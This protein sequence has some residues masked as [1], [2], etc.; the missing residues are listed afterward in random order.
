MAYPDKLLADDEEIVEH[1]HPHWITLVPAVASFIVICAA[2][3]VGLAFLPDANAH[4]GAHKA[5]LIAVLVLAL[6]LLVWLVLIPVVRW[7]STH[8][9]IT[10]HRVLIRRGV[11]N[12]VGRDITLARI[13]DV[14]YE[15][16]IWDRVVR[17][18]SLTIESAGEHGQET[19]VNI[20]RANEIQQTLNRLIEADSMRRSRGQ[21]RGSDTEVDGRGRGGSLPDQGY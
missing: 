12:H 18:G 15:Q 5:V 10:S 3:G 2:A 14:A 19:L 1:L 17:S 9:V 7:R 4:P 20:P 11:L 8:Y 21:Y 16:S 13:N 6:L